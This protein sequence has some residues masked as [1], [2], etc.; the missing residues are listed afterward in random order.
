MRR[1]IL[2]TIVAVAAL[3]VVAFFLPAAL[4][5]RSRIQRGD[6][7]ELQREASI[8]ASR[9]PATG[10]IAPS[11][12]AEVIE[13]GHDVGFY[14]GAGDLIEGQGPRL[15]DRFVATALH[16][17]FAEGYEHG[18]LVAAVPLRPGPDGAALVVR[19]REPRAQSQA[20]VLRSVG[21]LGLAAIGVIAAAALIGLLLARRLNRPVEDLR[22]WAA[23]LGH[24]EG[25]PPAAGIPELDDLAGAM[26]A[27]S[28]RVRDL[29]RRERSFSSHVSH[30][31]RTP[32][33]AMRV[34][35]ETELDAPR[36][37]ST[38]VLG[39]C[40]GELDRLE[41]TVTSLLALAR[42]DD[43]EPTWC[44][45]TALVRVQADR[46][47]A[48]FAA[49]GRSIETRGAAAWA[50]VDPAVVTHIVDVLLDNALVHG[51]GTVTVHARAT[52]SAV[53]VEVGDEGTP[54]VEADPF[55]ERRPDSGHGIGLRLART[56]TESQ[57][58]RLDL[59]EGPRTVF[60][61]TLP[62]ERA[63]V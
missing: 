10:P 19:I 41:R 6:L 32:V 39:E 33:A 27:S 49:A 44:D 22:R 55:S 8:I 47:R 17:M 1:R 29:L 58:G 38:E 12:V 5:I 62:G 50:E 40:L 48:P 11:S 46:W 52:P 20:R 9:I 4:A 56:L 61:L 21:W 28:E 34:A 63:T 60:Q 24:D 42:H 30:Q 36:P 31:L 37:D 16:G 57:G 15:P 59:E 25:P 23:D 35:V 26:A 2:V 43:R 45:V 18:D 7:L 3:A 54:P 14:D 53:E 51:R 13:D